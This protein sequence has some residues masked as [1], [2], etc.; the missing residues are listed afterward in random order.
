MELQS[1]VFALHQQMTFQL[2]SGCHLLIPNW[3]VSWVREILDVLCVLLLFV[4]VPPLHPYPLLLAPLPSKCTLYALCDPLVTT[5]QAFV[6]SL[7][8]YPLPPPL[9]PLSHTQA[10]Q[11]C[12]DPSTTRRPQ[13]VEFTAPEQSARPRELVSR[14]SLCLVYYNLEVLTTL[15][16]EPS[17]QQHKYLYWYSYRQR[18]GVGGKGVYRRVNVRYNCIPQVFVFVTVRMI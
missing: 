7:P 13:V 8:L 15:Q 3:R 12:I 2:L 16:P 5:S 1:S 10:A 9:H 17:P 6:L 11:Q 4:L 14:S 18:L